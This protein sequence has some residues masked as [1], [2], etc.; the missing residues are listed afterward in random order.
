[1]WFQYFVSEVVQYFAQ[2]FSFPELLSSSGLLQGLTSEV[3]YIDWS[4][5]ACNISY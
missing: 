3:Y 1:M 4:F 2:L 5:C